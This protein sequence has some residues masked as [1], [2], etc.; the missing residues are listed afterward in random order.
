VS[1]PSPRVVRP[2]IHD[3]KIPDHQIR[4]SC[5][6]RANM[7]GTLVKNLPESA[8]NKYRLDGVVYQR[9]AIA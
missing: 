1:M 2:L 4:S 9:S 5:P 8:R 6:R 7:N 3:R